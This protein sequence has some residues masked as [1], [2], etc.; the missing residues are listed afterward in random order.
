MTIVG[1]L[2]WGV[3]ALGAAALLLPAT[4]SS[5]AQE[6]RPHRATCVAIPEDP[7]SPEVHTTGSCQATHLGREAFE[8]DHT[9]VPTG[10]PDANGLVP[11]AVVGGRATHVAANGDQLRSEYE[12]TGTVSLSSG[13]IVFALDGRYTGGTGRFEGASGT[14]RITGVVEGG[15]ARF[16]EE[17]SITY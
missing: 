16:V 8:A 2:Q 12:G 6:T 1:R 17:G 14:T 5:S 15:V 3:A 13:R 7:L 11:I 4:G 9:V 10:A